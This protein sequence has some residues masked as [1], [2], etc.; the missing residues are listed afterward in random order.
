MVYASF[1]NLLVEISILF[2]KDNKKI[3]LIDK[4]SK[5]VAHYI[6]KSK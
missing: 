5:I 6:M 1:L 2:Q 3:V 4:H